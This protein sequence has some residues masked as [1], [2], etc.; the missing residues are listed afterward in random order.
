MSWF[1]INKTTGQLYLLVPTD[2]LSTSTDHLSTTG[3][4]S[5]S[6]SIQLVIKATHDCWSGYW[7][8]PTNGRRRPGH[9]TARDGVLLVDVTVVMAARFT[10]TSLYAAV[11]PQAPPGHRV[12][13]LMVSY[14][15]C[16]SC[17]YTD[18]PATCKCNV[19]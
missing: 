15:H 1:S 13:S 9:V 3:A 11:L 14:S 8:L 2:H 12:I 5:G 18:R 19:M 6:Q 7:E 4:A 16:S 17:K 10:V